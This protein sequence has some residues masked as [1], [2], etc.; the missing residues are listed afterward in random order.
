M[1]RTTAITI[2]YV[3]CFAGCQ[4]PSTESN[5]I[6]QVGTSASDE[7][8]SSA[9]QASA[10]QPVDCTQCADEETMERD[11]PPVAVED[12]TPS[13]PPPRA[14]NLATPDDNLYAWRKTRASL[15]PEEDVVFYWSGYIYNLVAKDPADYA[16]TGDIDF[17]SPIF[18]F[19]GFNVARFAE[20]GPGEYM[21]LSREIS[22]YRDPRTNA[23][24]DC[25]T[26]TLRSD[27]LEVRPMH[28]TNDPV[29]FGVGTM[30]YIEL[31]DRVSFFSDILL[32]YRSPLAGQDVYDNFSASDVYQSNELFNFIVSKKDLENPSIKSA[33]VEISWTRMGQYLPWMQMGDQAGHLIYHVRGYKVP[34]GVDGLPESLREWTENNAGT[35]FLRSPQEVPWDY[36]PNATTWRVFRAK[37]DTESYDPQCD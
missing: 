3:Y 16:R 26:N 32:A 12:T 23:I 28:V 36:A 34:N 15:D 8:P 6:I 37:L 10:C 19:E 30:N 22:V 7:T 2:I 21:M 20:S 14:L 5:D 17:A 35:Q 18:K 31:G 25:W 24:I 33:S 4:S 13:T 9:P 27:P 1:K 29:N 11:V